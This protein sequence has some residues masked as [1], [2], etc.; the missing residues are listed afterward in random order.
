MPEPGS[1]R[2]WNAVLSD[3]VA[4]RWTDPETGKAADV[5]FQSIVIGEDLSGA[6]ADLVA[7]LGLG[8]RLAVV[9]DEN[10][11]EALGRRVAS[12]LRPIA[13][14]EQIVLPAGFAASE[15]AIAD[16]GEKTRGFDAIVAVGSGTINDCCKHATF[17]D[18]RPYAVFGTAASMNGYAA[19]TASM[20]LNSGLK[21]SIPSHAPRGIFLDLKVAASAPTRLRASGLGDSLCRP[22]AQIDWWAS[23]RLFGTHYTATPYALTDPEEAEMIATAPRLAGGDIDA[24]GILQRVLTLCAMGVCFTGVSN[25]GS[26]GEHLVSHWIDMVAGDRH[27]GTLHGEQVG[28]AA[29]AIMELQHRIL[30]MDKPPKV[31]PTEIDE[32]GMIE[33]YGPEVG[34]QCLA[35]FRKKALDE[36]GAAAMNRRLS[37]IWPQ[38]RVELNAKSM[39]VERMREALKAA[40]GATTGEEL[41]LDQDLWHQAMLHAREIRGRWSFLDFAADARMLEDFVRDLT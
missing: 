27:P 32:A 36:D 19:T 30:A 26:M 38:L 8:E 22:T 4:G 5:P 1:H 18:G 11:V 2:D 37:E 12:A 39:P 40:K 24:T 29:I 7:P 33:R 14:V 9:S 3:V 16:I 31:Y 25:H 20:K 21:A 34:A 28:V 13:N 10:T 17:L 6:E 23:H 35:E 41:G 15:A